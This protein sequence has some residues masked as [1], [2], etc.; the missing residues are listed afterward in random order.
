MPEPK[1]KESG[2]GTISQTPSLDARRATCA[3]QIHPLSAFRMP[4][5]L[6]PASISEQPPK[7]P[8]HG[9]AH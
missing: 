6:P 9:D 7:V 4:Y 3:P 8:H 5:S 2:L 1:T